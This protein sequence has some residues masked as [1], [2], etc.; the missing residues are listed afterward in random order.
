MVGMSLKAYRSSDRLDRPHGHLLMASLSV[1]EVGEHYVV[2]DNLDL[3]AG[4]AESIRL[5]EG[6]FVGEGHAADI[7]YGKVI[8]VAT[9]YG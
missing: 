1:K 6:S 9:S 4:L 8:V 7:R 5:A 3:G 2:E